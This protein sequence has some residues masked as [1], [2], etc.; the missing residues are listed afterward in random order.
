MIE[1]FLKADV[2]HQLNASKLL[3]IQGPKGV[4]K[5]TLLKEILDES[6]T[7][8]ETLDASDKKVRK[9]IEEKT[10]RLEDASVKVIII[11]E[12]QFLSNLQT[13]LERVL[14]GEISATIIVCCS[15]NPLIDAE[16]VEAMRMEG[17]VFNL[18]AP[19][20]NESAKHFGLS[21]ETALLEERLIFGNYPQV[22]S[23]LENAADTLDTMISDVI[24]KHIGAKDRVNKADKLMRMLQILAHQCGEPISYHDLGQRCGIDNETVERYIQLFEDAFVLIKLPSLFNDHRYELKKTHVVYFQD[25]GLRNAL[26][27]NFNPSHIRND[28]DQ[29]WRNYLISERVKWLRMN[30]IEKDLFF[31]RTHTQ[32]HMDFVEVGPTGT[33]AYKADP[34]M[35]SYDKRQKV[36]IPPSFQKYYPDAKTSVLNKTTYWNFLTRKA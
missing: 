4:G 33:M 7:V 2:L 8:F 14:T 29:L 21:E 9:S 22:L 34:A 27:R 11:R 28:M 25:N 3:L 32:Q 23:D 36:K 16:L 31:W 35:F 15:Y 5:Y 26:I 12:A 19:S 17:M 18:Y 6:S 24:S 1:R 13:L 30:N 20:F 10:L